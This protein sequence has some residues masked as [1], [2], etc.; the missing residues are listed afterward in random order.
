[1]NDDDDLCGIMID[2]TNNALIV[3]EE[4]PK[5]TKVHFL[6]S[7]L[8]RLEPDTLLIVSNIF[9][10]LNSFDYFFELFERASNFK[11]K[12]LFA[13]PSSID[14]SFAYE[15]IAINGQF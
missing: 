3:F 10:K 15:T 8:C 11:I 1:M 14:F 12:F 7:K 5:C 9:S 2:P 4:K 13:T 6:Q